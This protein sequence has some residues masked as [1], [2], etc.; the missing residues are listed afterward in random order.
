[1]R[2]EKIKILEI[3]ND[4]TLVVINE[5]GKAMGHKKEKNQLHS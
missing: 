4:K 5:L 3:I 2:Q 1:M